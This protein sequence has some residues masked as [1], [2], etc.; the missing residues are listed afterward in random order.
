MEFYNAGAVDGVPKYFTDEDEATYKLS[1]PP[2][3]AHVMNVRYL[4]LPPRLVVTTVETNWLTDNVPEL[5]FRACL[6]ESEAFLKGDERIPVWKSDYME[7]LALTKRDVY[8][9]QNTQHEKLS[10]NGVALANRSAM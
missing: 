8:P 10:M 5:L 4:S 1:P 3:A 2:A 6:V 7:L 9:Q